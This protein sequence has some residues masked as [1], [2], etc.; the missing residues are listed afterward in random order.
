MDEKNSNV[1]LLEMA[2]Y[3]KARSVDIT[4]RLDKFLQ[5]SLKFD[6]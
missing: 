6:T 4:L 5:L 2:Y 3:E 1:D